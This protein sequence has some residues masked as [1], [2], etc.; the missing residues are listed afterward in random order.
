ML[1]ERR[2]WKWLNLGSAGLCMHCDLWREIGRYIQSSRVIFWGTWLP[3]GSQ[4]NALAFKNFAL[5]IFIVKKWK[6]KQIKEKKGICNILLFPP[7]SQNN[8]IA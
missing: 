5:Y 1:S 3:L 4:G 6:K 7:F 2:T 8:L